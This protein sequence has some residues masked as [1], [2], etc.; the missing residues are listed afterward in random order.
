METSDYMTFW[1]VS[2]VFLSLRVVE[3]FEP[4]FHSISIV[5]KLGGRSK[6]RY[7]CSTLLVSRLFH[8]VSSCHSF[9]RT[10]V[11][12]IRTRHCRLQRSCIE[13][14]SGSLGFK[15]AFFFYACSVRCGTGGYAKFETKVFGTQVVHCS[16]VPMASARVDLP[17][18]C[19][20]V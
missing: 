1:M 18:S 14:S 16:I 19:F 2:G 17:S 9:L 10:V 13:G 4:K 11:T 20:L 12:L 6:T 8:D 7:R 15:T 3:F 5:T